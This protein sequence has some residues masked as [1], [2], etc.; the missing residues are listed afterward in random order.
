MPFSAICTADSQWAAS[1]LLL[2]SVELQGPVCIY[3]KGTC[4][5]ALQDYI[6]PNNRHATLFYHDHSVGI[7]SENV[8]AGKHRN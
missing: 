1:G 5:A 2:C 4:A 6:L 7:T 3:S 8:Y